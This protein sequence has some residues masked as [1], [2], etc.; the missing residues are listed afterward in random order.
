ML[1]S[2]FDNI[3]S[4][5]VVSANGAHRAVHVV[6]SNHWIVDE[7]L[8]VGRQLKTTAHSHTCTYLRTEPRRTASDTRSVLM[9]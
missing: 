9:S 7:V 5:Q 8:T 4:A 3:I 6:M 1:S 2:V